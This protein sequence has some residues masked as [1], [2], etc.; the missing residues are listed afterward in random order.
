VPLTNV[1]IEIHIVLL[2][3]SHNTKN[4][5]YHITEVL[6]FY[7][8]K[9]VVMGNCKNSHVLKSDAHEI[10]TVNHKNVTLYF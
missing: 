4:T 1:I 8:D 7:A 3:T 10:Y 9:L 6:R 5:V 2:F